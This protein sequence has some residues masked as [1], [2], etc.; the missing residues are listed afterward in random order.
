MSNY[1][2]LEYELALLRRQRVYDLD[3]CVDAYKSTLK[4]LA[5]EKAARETAETDR[6][7]WK[8][9]S[10]LMQ[11]QRDTRFAEANQA[12]TECNEAQTRSLDAV[13]RNRVTAD[14]ATRDAAL[15][16]EKD[17]RIAELV[18]ELGAMELRA[19]SAETIAGI[20][21]HKCPTCKGTRMVS[22]QM[23]VNTG[24]KL[25]Y[26]DSFHDGACP[27]CAGGDDMDETDARDCGDK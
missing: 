25:G 20:A 13:R 12:R 23:K 1:V 9:R 3:C 18:E 5:A 8:E 4:R 11:S 19:R 14:L 17:K 10:E 27:D 24:G 26:V 21:L 6:D 15:I 2:E 7:F 22:V 16:A